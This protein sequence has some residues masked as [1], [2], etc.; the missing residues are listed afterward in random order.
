LD[1]AEERR[2]FEEWFEA[3]AMPLESDWFRRDPDAPD[4]YASP[5]VQCAWRGW[6]ARAG[7]PCDVEAD[8]ET[9]EYAELA[10]LAGS[11]STSKHL[12]GDPELLRR[13]DF[14]EDCDFG[15]C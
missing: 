10:R 9:A 5:S 13:D 12:T 8:L 4:E 7:L 11:I 1:R 6:A 3:D 15:L 2:R 14:P